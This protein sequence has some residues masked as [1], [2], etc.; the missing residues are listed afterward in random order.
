MKTTFYELSEAQRRQL[1]DAESLFE[2]VERTQEEA[3]AHRGSMFWRE[4][5]G[6]TYLIQ[7]STDSRQRSLGRESDDTRKTFESF[8]GRKQEVEARLKSLRAQLDVTRRVNRAL[9]IGRTP[10]LLVGVL[11]ELQKVGVAEHF[12]VVGTNALFAYETAAGVRFPGDVMETRDADLLYDSRPR[13]A[14]QDT[15]FLDILRRVDKTF[16]RHPTESCRAVNS[17]GYEIGLICRFQPVRASTGERLLSVPRFEQIV[18]SQSGSMARMRT[19]HPMAFARIKRQLAASPQ[20]DPRKATKDML[21]AELVEQMVP[22]YLPH[23]GNKPEV[24]GDA[25]PE[26]SVRLEGEGGPNFE[27]GR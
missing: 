22:Q 13:V 1:L 12:L 4:Q 6:R 15:S 2:L 21:Q 8:M 20:R 16:E 18:V 24:D 25:S 27:S 14:G 3:W 9:R 5:S 10:D 23:L 17:K 26:P 11:T 7:L 19:V